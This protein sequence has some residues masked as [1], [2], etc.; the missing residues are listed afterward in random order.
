[1]KNKWHQIVIDGL[2]IIVQLGRAKG[3]KLNQEVE[4]SAHASDEGAAWSGHRRECHWLRSIQ[5]KVLR[6]E[7][8]LEASADI[9]MSTWR[10]VKERSIRRRV[11]KLRDTHLRAASGVQV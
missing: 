4:Q 11:R 2:S 1:M 7:H 9:R 6:L 3:I 5:L 10:S 8:A